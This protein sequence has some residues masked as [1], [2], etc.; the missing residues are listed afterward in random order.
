VPSGSL[1]IARR[2]SR[3]PPTAVG[4]RRKRKKAR[5]ARIDAVALRGASV[6]QEVETEIERR[7][8]PGY[9]K[10]AS[11]LLDLRTIA[12]MRGTLVEFGRRLC[13]IRERHAQKRRFIDRLEKLP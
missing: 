4:K 6:W 2:Q 10:A 8:A 9:D 7:N 12:E 5:R 1:V 3:L 13:E 11:L